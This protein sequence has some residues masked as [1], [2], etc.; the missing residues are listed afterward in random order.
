MLCMGREKPQKGQ[1]SKK[2]TVHTFKKPQ[3]VFY[4]CKKLTDI[5]R[6]PVR[7]ISRSRVLYLIA[8]GCV[9]VRS[10]KTRRQCKKRD[11]N[12]VSAISLRLIFLSFLFASSSTRCIIF[13]SISRRGFSY[14]VPLFVLF[15]S[16]LAAPG[17]RILAKSMR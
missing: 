12:R 4:P 13:S 14:G 8:R 1:N 5:T 7:Y 17:D 6:I 16:Q 11:I 2:Y 3:A 15:Q 10:R 9:E